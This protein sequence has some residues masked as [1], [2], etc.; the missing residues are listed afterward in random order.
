[1]TFRD[2]VVEL[3]RVPAGELQA[4]PRNWRTHPPAQRKALEVMLA[5]VGFAG[6]ALGRRDETGRIILVDGHLRSDMAADQPIPVLIL[7]ID[8]T[9]AGRLL[10]TLDPI[11]A[12]A[13]RDDQALRDL[14]E[15]I[16][17]DEHVRAA[18]EAVHNF[19]LVEFLAR[20]DANEPPI[21]EGGGRCC[22]ND[23]PT[24]RPVDHG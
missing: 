6:A 10:A 16:R 24:G 15:A 7:D 5:D 21:P 12:L 23:H 19:K 13:G 17:P 18:L 14:L 9:E 3:V 11:G 8:E 20:N 4:D 2:R 1:M 22:R